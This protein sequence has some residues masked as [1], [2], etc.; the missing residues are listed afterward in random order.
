MPT[1]IRTK[2]SGSSR[3]A[4]R[5]CSARTTRR[6]VRSPPAPKTTVA[7]G[8]A[9]RAPDIARARIRLQA[10]YVYIME[11]AA[12]VHS[13]EIG[14]ALSE[15]FEVVLRSDVHRGYIKHCPRAAAGYPRSGLTVMV[16]R[17]GLPLCRRGTRL[18]AGK[19]HDADS[20]VGGNRSTTKRLARMSSRH[21]YYETQSKK[22]PPGDAEIVLMSRT[23]GDAC[24]GQRFLRRSPPPRPRGSGAAAR[25]TCR[26][27]RPT[28]WHSRPRRPL[29]Q[30]RCQPGRPLRRRLSE[31]TPP[32]RPQRHAHSRCRH[33]IC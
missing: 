22:L 19:V 7:H 1:P 13:W 23:A 17:N 9:G 11:A 12:S 16:E 25:S 15:W 33:R 27:R 32:R 24:A 18:R 8:P 31:R 5:L 20:T 2:S 21:C 30:Y 14:A 26:S 6:R 28:D 10:R 4:M 29:R 3:P